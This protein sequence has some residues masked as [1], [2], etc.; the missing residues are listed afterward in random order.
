MKVELGEGRG[1]VFCIAEGTPMG[2]AQDILSRGVEL[3]WTGALAA[4]PLVILVSLACRWRG[5]RPATRHLLWLAALVSFITP[6]IGVT[7]W[8]PEWF[9]SDR[10]LD[11]VKNVVPAS[12]EAERPK[13]GRPV[14]SPRAAITLNETPQGSQRV[15]P[16]VGPNAAKSAA[17]IDRGVAGMHPA[18]TAAIRDDSVRAGS[19]R[20]VDMMPMPAGP[21]VLYNGMMYSTRSD[22]PR[23][24]A[25]V[26]TRPTM[27]VRPSM[28]TSE[29]GVSSRPARNAHSTNLLAREPAAVQPAAAG[30]GLS[31][32]GNA[33]DA[34]DAADAGVAEERRTGTVD[35]RSWLA[36][37]LAVRDA[38]RDLPPL[39]ASLWFA[40][41]AVIL[42][43]CVWRTFLAGLWIRGARPVS[44]EVQETVEQ[45]GT[46]LGLRRTPKAVFVDGQ[47][48]PMIWCGLRP[49]LVLPTGLW[50]S[51][52]E[53]S[54]RAVIVHELAHVRRKDHLVCWLE[55]IV[56][57]VYWWHPAVWW[58]R[59]RL[60]DEAEASCDAWVTSLF[61]SDRKAYASALVVA[62][63]YL[64]P[65]DMAG[66][67][68]LGMA[69]GS[70]KRL[71]R[72]ITMVMTERTAPKMSMV[73]MGVAALVV[74]AGTFVMPGLACPPDKTETAA[75]NKAAIAG[76]V[77]TTGKTAVKTTNGKQVITTA[78]GQVYI[79]EGQGQKAKKVDGV[80]FLGEGPALDAMRAGEPMTTS[81]KATA[82]IE[83]RGRVVT[84]ARPGAAPK[85][86]K[87]PKAPGTPAAIMVPGSAIAPGA[88]TVPGTRYHSLQPMTTMSTTAVG[89][90]FQPA[91]T[92]QPDNDFEKLK[93]G[94]EPKA[95]HL[96]AG[97]LQCFYSLMSRQDVPIL[98]EMNGDSITIWGNE[99]EHKVFKGFVEIIGKG[100]D[101]HPGAATVEG[102][103]F[104]EARAGQ[105]AERARVDAKRAAE[106]YRSS[107]KTF[108]KMRGQIE[109]DADKAREDA[110]R[111]R[112]RAEE[113]RDTVEELKARS[114]SMSKNEDRRAID[115]AIQSLT[116]H[117]TTLQ[118]QSK[119]TEDRL[120]ALEK[121]LEELER[122]AERIEEKLGAL[123]EMEEGEEIAIDMIEVPMIDD[124][125][126]EAPIEF[127]VDTTIEMPVEDM[128]E[129][130]AIEIDEVELVDP[131]I[132]T[133]P[134][135][136]TAPVAPTAPSATPALAPLP[137]LPSV[138]AANAGPATP[139]GPS[140]V[141]GP[142][143]PPPT[144]VA[145]PAA[146][147]PVAPTP[148]AAR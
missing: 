103:F 1:R 109:R 113:M 37:V 26:E 115:T 131:V 15:S 84:P 82:P 38:L 129:V 83:V 143:T 46:A 92:T 137:T 22:I 54:R 57:A 104:P 47:V 138:P 139:P 78:E 64:G 12:P 117:S 119:L 101:A 142:G 56:G 30:P 147:P 55:G 69:S 134:V 25:S 35:V 60:H 90:S 14:E 98:V 89:R 63:S 23:S 124:S 105:A 5:L 133:E 62:K 128:I 7:L 77:K 70:A 107:L 31:A 18:L 3:L 33:A 21:V 141:P 11:A 4:T 86:P 99:A 80:E 93:E 81:P 29:K 130:P 13:A 19:G 121:Q 65:R 34:A 68:W 132:A 10:V 85:A 42:T 49:R 71:A 17:T 96:P 16:E 123:D 102:R 24:V 127:D 28:T 75:G 43:V 106:Q 122:Q 88:V 148:I 6:V 66:G 59:R 32:E 51:L 61:P 145:P 110:D 136:A 97:K 45:V 9:R 20:A 73:G 36:G 8:R 72:R 67:R 108:E 144:P 79:I 140:S 50:R 48:S 27:D 58:A 111:E 52:G 135:A 53:D 39:P 95:Y 125:M 44:P 146:L 114:K 41:T 87:A 2:S 40:G 116:T 74:A 118:S 100:G 76:T 112:E 94:R 91:F 120:A 126:F